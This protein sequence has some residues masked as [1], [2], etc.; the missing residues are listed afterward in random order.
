MIIFTFLLS[1]MRGYSQSQS[2]QHYTY[3]TNQNKVADLFHNNNPYYQCKTAKHCVPN[4]DGTPSQKKLAIFLLDKQTGIVVPTFIQCFENGDAMASMAESLV[5]I[6]NESLNNDPCATLQNYQGRVPRS[7][8]EDTMQALDNYDE[9]GCPREDRSCGQQMYELMERDLKNLVRP[10]ASQ[11]PATMEMGCLSNIIANLI[12]GLWSTLKLVAWELPRGLWNA[13]VNT[14]NYFF[15]Q[16]A[17]TSTAMLYASVMSEPMASA[18]SRGDFSKF[19]S[20]LRKNFFGFLGAIREFYSELMGCNEW[21]GA[22]FESECLNRTNW[23][24]PTCESVTNFLCGLSGQIGSGMML[25]ALLGVVKTGASLAMYKKSI[26]QS[27]QNYGIVSDALTD[28]QSRQSVQNIRRGIENL[29]YQTR[30]ALTPTRNFLEAATG[31][32]K[33]LFAFGTNTRNLMAI[34]P[35]TAPFH[36]AF[37]TGSRVSQRLVHNLAVDGKLPGLSL[38]PTLNLSRRFGQAITKIQDSFADKLT[39]LHRMTGQNINPR[40]LADVERRYLHDVKSELEHLN[41][42]TQLSPDGQSLIIEK[43]GESFTYAPNLAQKLGDAPAGMPI[44][45]FRSFMTNSDPL[46]DRITPSHRLLESTPAFLREIRTRGDTAASTFVTK[47]GPSDGYAYLS[48]FSA[49]SK[50]VPNTKKC[51]DLLFET[52]VLRVHDVTA[53]TETSP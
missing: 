26:S 33:M 11:T 6:V 20:E 50:S 25:G 1:P 7:F 15:D 42:K 28:F 16:E 5:P 39:D 21:S 13:G 22:P 29:R 27:P 41:I 37:Q 9:E 48:Y 18:L 30:L 46:L 32:M 51:D 12:D 49:Q 38:S 34:N 4:A 14:W 3:I 24:C 52:E 23:S 19:Y 44:D 47:V 36:I 8:I 53:Q 2:Q 45:D 35:V 31:E 10:F 40:I 17:E 43:G